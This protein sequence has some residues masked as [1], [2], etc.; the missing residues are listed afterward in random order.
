[1]VQ[2]L[3]DMQF[4]RDSEDKPEI[5][6][7]LPGAAIAG[8]E[9]EIRGTGFLRGGRA[10]VLVGDVQAPVI[11]GSQS[12][13][14]AKV[15]DG[16]DNG[17]LL[18]DNGERL[19]SIWNCEIGIQLAEDL[20]PVSSPA[21]DSQGNIFTT[22]SGTRGQKTPVS[23][24]KIDSRK[25]MTPFLS[26]I[27]NPTG[28]AFDRE[29][30][31]YISSRNDE[32]VYQC[33]PSGQLSIFV[34][35]MGTATGLAFDD[36]GNLYV[37][38]RSGTIFKVSPTRQIYVFATVEP[39]I[40]AYHM[41]FGSDQHLYITGPTTSSYDVVHRVAPDGQVEIFFRGLGRPQGLA[42]DDAGNL[43]VSSSL[44]GRR[45]VV[46]ITPNKEASLFLSG[47]GIVGLAFTPSKAMAIATNNAIFRVNVGIAG[48]PIWG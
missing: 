13:I 26:D 12:F 20:H 18:V 16:A 37:G 31:L 2:S 6:Q 9:L 42:F 47:P 46:R 7:V 27:M 32:I 30:L 45:G 15:P 28:L 4:F 22:F 11:I 25:G 24:Y 39:S 5:A 8:G 17:N 23:V 1:M 14:I 34:E 21:V 33:T 19:S 38:D 40:A 43:Y 35:G 48:R 29:G 36:E 3:L 10:K 44:A 41:T